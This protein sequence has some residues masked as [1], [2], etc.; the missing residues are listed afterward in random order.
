M[1]ATVQE[2]TLTS[3]VRSLIEELC[4]GIDRRR[5][6]LMDQRLKHRASLAE[7]N[8]QFLDET[9]HIRNGKW[10][11]DT[12]PEQLLERRVELLGGAT[13]SELINGLNSGSK[14]YIADLWNFTPID[15]WNILRAHRSLAR[16]AKLDLAY[17]S[18]EGGRIRVNP[19][20]TTRLMVV[21]RPMNVHESAVLYNGEPVAASF[22]DL[23]LLIMNSGKELVARQGGIFLML[24]DVQTHLEARLWVQ[25]FDILEE[26]MGFDR[27][28]IKATIMIDTIPAALEA[29]EILFEMIHHVAGM[30]LDPQ[31]YAADHIALFNGEDRPVFPDR[32]IIGLNAPF[33]RSLGL[34]LVSVCHARGCHAIGAPSFV[35]PPL[36]PERMKASYL[37]MLADKERE[38]VDGF[39][40]TIV[41]HADTV[42]AAMVEYNKSMPRAN[43]LYYQRND[44][45]QPSDLIR[46]PEGKITV[47]S[48][49][50]MI[51]TALRSMVRSGEGKGWVIQGGRM[52]DRS[53]L[54]LTARLLWQW[55]KSRQG[56]I[57]TSGLDVHDDLIK[58]LVKKESE[59]M[60][61]EENDRIK[62]L[63]SA[64]E[65][66][67]LE[68]V[69]GKELPVEPFT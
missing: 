8:V 27:G 59:K 65:K 58:Y 4:T 63:A 39:D 5:R 13:R 48:L 22:F 3:E 12:I 44:D 36:D 51:R 68:L 61:G 10:T 18:P 25:L 43:Q 64:S 66:R 35:L 56:V 42:N 19:K 41:V 15:T 17:L 50:G 45:V 34:H 37:E 7:G 30:S 28:T 60:F 26:H 29:E 38:A 54:R 33:L 20:T 11:V 62:K 40:G 53:S 69:L 14:S 21:P 31:G 55:N 23:A 9:H 16:A 24:R 2:R 6:E 32:E 46:R 1:I 67:L 47:D 52:H 57:T 49:V